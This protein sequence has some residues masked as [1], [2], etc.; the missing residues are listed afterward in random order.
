MSKI[1]NEE[2]KI[3]VPKTET[4]DPSRA[5]ERQLNEEPKCVESRMERNDPILPSP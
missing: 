2:P 3:A 1:D 5:N 4:E